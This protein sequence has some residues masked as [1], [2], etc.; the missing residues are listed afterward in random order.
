MSQQRYMN[1]AMK[2]PRFSHLR[3]IWKNKSKEDKSRTNVTQ[4]TIE[5]ETGDQYAEEPLADD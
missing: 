3:K 4:N 5:E 2:K 1:L